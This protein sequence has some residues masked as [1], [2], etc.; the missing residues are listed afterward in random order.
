MIN[1]Q[2]ILVVMLMVSATH[3]MA[4]EQTQE[5]RKASVVCTTDASAYPFS[6]GNDRCFKDISR[7]GQW[8]RL[9]LKSATACA[10]NTSDGLRLYFIYSTEAQANCVFMSNPVPRAEYEWGLAALGDEEK[11]FF[12]EHAQ[13]N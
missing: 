3:S 5:T 7:N 13:S 11:A 4:Q 8:V 2:Q 10:I 12:L 6:A 9:A 1:V